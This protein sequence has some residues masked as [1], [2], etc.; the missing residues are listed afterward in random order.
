MIR[1]RS[2]CALPSALSQF[3]YAVPVDHRAPDR[4]RFAAAHVQR[5][6]FDGADPLAVAGFH[7][8]DMIADAVLLPVKEDALP[9]P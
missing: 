3:R 5:I 9:L 8:S 1:R 2:L 4:I 6:A 7:D